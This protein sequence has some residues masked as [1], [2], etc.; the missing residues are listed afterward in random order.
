[1]SDQLLFQTEIFFS[2]T[3]HSA[4][5]IKGNFDQ[6]QI[7]SVGKYFFL[8]FFLVTYHDYNQTILS[9]N[10]ML[11]RAQ[12]D[13]SKE[14]KTRTVTPSNLYIYISCSYK[15]LPTVQPTVL[16]IY[17]TSPKLFTVQLIQY[18]THQ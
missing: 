18:Q 15:E 11:C 17:L 1:M 5:N 16:L 10:N 9:C 14:V 2:V 7:F 3:V 8:H 13:T 12:L 4:E 6:T